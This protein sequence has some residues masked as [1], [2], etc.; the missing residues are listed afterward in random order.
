MNGDSSMAEFTLPDET[1]QVLSEIQTGSGI[2]LSTTSKMFPNHR[3]KG[4]ADPSTVFRW[5]T[6]GTKTMV[7]KFVKLEAVR[8]GGRWLTSKEAVVRFVAALTSA[9]TPTASNNPNT[10][11]RNSARQK[12]SEEAAKLLEQMG[13]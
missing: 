8:V 5:V 9:A 1:S 11:P 10:N 7:G 12:E 2:S 4:T 13:A 6:K 3:G